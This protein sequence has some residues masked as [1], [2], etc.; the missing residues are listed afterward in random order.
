MSIEERVAKLE[1]RILIAE[2]QL[3]IMR[4]IHTYGPL[5]DSDEFEDAARIW[6]DGGI[7]DTDDRPSRSVPTEFVE[8]MQPQKELNAIGCTHFYSVPQITIDRDRADAINYSLV[9]MKDEEREDR[10][11]YV[12]R[13]AVNH[14]MLVRTSKGWR[15]RHRRNHKIDGSHA[16]HELMR[17]AQRPA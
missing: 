2:D 4:L 9:V 1:Q 8:V 13:S 17:R 12:M 14:W 7:H 5:M 11:F 15:V 16:S 6:V 10:A 3:E